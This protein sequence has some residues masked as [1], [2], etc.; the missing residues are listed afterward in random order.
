[1][2]DSLSLEFLTALLYTKRE[3]RLFPY[4]RKCDADGS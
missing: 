2:I 4:I 3:A 1:L